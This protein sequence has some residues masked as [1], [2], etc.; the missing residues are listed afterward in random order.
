MIFFSGKIF[1]VER[2]YNKQKET[3]L[4]ERYL[5]KTP[6]EVAHVRLA[7]TNILSD[8]ALKYNMTSNTK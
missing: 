7:M 3:F 6:V 1:I 8:F 4:S 2:K 5:N